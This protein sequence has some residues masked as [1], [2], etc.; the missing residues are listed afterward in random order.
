MPKIFKPFTDHES[1]EIWSR[2]YLKRI[3]TIAREKTTFS[4]DFRIF[5]LGLQRVSNNGHSPFLINEIGNLLI[6]TE[7]KPFVPKHVNN[8]I[9]V[10][11]NVGLLAPVSTSRCLVYPKELI[12]LKTDRKKVALCQEHGTH[13]SWSLFNNDWAPD[14]LPTIQESVISK[15][16]EEQ[17]V[18][19]EDLEFDVDTGTYSS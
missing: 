14:Y 18:P 13:R 10:L 8:Q 11:I 4:T 9:K 5:L 2:I 15:P 3:G 19:D 6:R 12:L 7:G 16:I 1:D 17:I